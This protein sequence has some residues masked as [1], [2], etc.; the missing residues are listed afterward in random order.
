MKRRFSLLVVLLAVF[1]LGATQTVAAGSPTTYSGRATVVDTT[2][3]G[4]DVNL[5][6][7][8][9]L[10]AGGGVLNESLLAT[11]LP[12]TLVAGISHALTIGQSSFSRSDASLADVDLTV[13]GV[14]LSADL[15]QAT[16]EARCANGK[17]TVSGSSLIVNLALNGQP[18]TVT[19][20]PN[21]TI[22]LPLGL[23]QLVINEQ[24]KTV[25]GRNGHIAVNAIHLTVTGIADVIL[26]HAE[27]GINCGRPNACPATTKIGGSGTME[28]NGG[29]KA[30]FAV[31]GG[32]R[33][34]NFFGHLRFDDKAGTKVSSTAV[35]NYEVTGTKSRRITG[36]AKINGGGSFTFTVDLTDNGKAKDD[37]IRVRL[38]NGYDTGVQKLT[39]Q[40]VR[41]C[42]NIRLHKGCR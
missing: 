18:I 34:N 17:A 1:G 7:T 35:T 13:A 28:L 27:S 29:G 6:D 12:G 15:I 20:Q 19:G 23:G 32:V 33:N 31:V 10:P 39:G 41:T 30:S 42:G 14:G 24:I 16:S 8:G 2:I 25:N 37:T 9:P 3:L 26:S 36:T 38:S 40:S 22:Q 4:I 11:E 5:T 21:Q